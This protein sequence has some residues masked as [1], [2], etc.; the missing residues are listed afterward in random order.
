M[1]SKA[2]RL[3]WFEAN[4]ADKHPDLS[5]DELSRS[6]RIEPE[7]FKSNIA[8]GQEF[9]SMAGSVVKGFLGCTLN[10]FVE[11][12]RAICGDGN[13]PAAGQSAGDGTEA[14]LERARKILKAGGDQAQALKTILSLMGK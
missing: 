6:F 10:E 4:L 3:K 5:I 2:D 12:G 8:S 9:T 7:V 14:L 1:D 11:G 13:A